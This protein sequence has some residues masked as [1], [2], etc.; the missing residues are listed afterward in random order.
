[1]DITVGRVTHY[2]NHIGVAVLVLSGELKAGDNILIMG[3][4]TEL[5]QGVASLEINHHKIQSASAGMEVALKVDE[6][7]REGDVVYK[8]VD[9]G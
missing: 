4:T 3:K 5:T 9:N 1:M 7:V 8:V 2:Y 6:P